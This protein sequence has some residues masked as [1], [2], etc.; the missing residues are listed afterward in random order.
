ME[1][2]LEAIWVDGDKYMWDGEA[3]DGPDE[4]DARAKTYAADGFQ[5]QVVECDGGCRVYTRRVVTEIEVEG[6]API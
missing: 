5:T 1:M 6:E 4:A 2:A 3:Y